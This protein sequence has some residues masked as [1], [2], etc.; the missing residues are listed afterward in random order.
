[1]HSRVTEEIT[2]SFRMREPVLLT[3]AGFT[4]NFGGFLASEMW[5]RLFNHQ[6]IQRYPSLV[7]RLK[8]DFAFEAVYHQVM[9]GTESTLEE[10]HAMQTAV[11]DA[12]TQLDDA[13][14]DCWSA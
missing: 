10:R 13:I 5:S 3:G 1:M 11:L 2:V 8:H 9:Y 6:E 14:R 12:Y 7:H 4:A